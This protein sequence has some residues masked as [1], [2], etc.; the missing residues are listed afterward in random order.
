MVIMRQTSAWHFGR[1][2]CS[3]PRFSLDLICAPKLWVHMKKKLEFS[4][5]G[6]PSSTNQQ[7]GAI[8]LFSAL[9]SFS[10]VP[11]VLTILLMKGPSFVF[12]LS[13]PLWGVQCHQ[14][15]SQEGVLVL[16]LKPESQPKPA[17]NRALEGNGALS[18]LLAASFPQHHEQ[19]SNPEPPELLRLSI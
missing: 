4:Q 13:F 1:H 15:F 16:L 5:L 6:T 8:D 3:S 18:I 10:W 2:V 11:Y 14:Q 19:F 7:Q 17:F 12:P 9:Q